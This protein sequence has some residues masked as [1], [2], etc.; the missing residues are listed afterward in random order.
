[1]LGKFLPLKCRLD[2]FI[3]DF[4]ASL[5]SYAFS[6][7]LEKVVV[8]GNCLTMHQQ[9]ESFKGKKQYCLQANLVSWIL[10][11]S[12]MDANYKHHVCAK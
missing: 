10:E 11:S 12:K 7:S 1:M 2:K 3:I 8:E 9:V 5:A 4:M 6:F